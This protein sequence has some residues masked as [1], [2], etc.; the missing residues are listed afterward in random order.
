MNRH[1]RIANNDPCNAIVQRY[2]YNNYCI[3]LTDLC[4][5]PSLTGCGDHKVVIQSPR[6]HLIGDSCPLEVHMYHM[7]NGSFFHSVP[8]LKCTNKSDG[9]LQARLQLIPMP[10][11]YRISGC[12]V[13]G[14]HFEK[15]LLTPFF[16]PR[17]AMVSITP[18]PSEPAE[19]TSPDTSAIFLYRVQN[20]DLVPA[21]V[22][23]KV[24]MFEESNVM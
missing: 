17:V 1:I 12:D 24:Q 15:V 20:M 13:N 5:D 21:T 8:L 7:S 2:C 22:T 9:F 16:S 3:H 19:I 18:D 23:F 11:T 6:M 10:L 4:A 14:I